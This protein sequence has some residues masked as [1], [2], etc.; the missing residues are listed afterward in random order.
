ML[1]VFKDLTIY[2]DGDPGPF[3][4]AATTQLPRAWTRNWERE[5]ELKKV[6]LTSEDRYVAFSRASSDGI[7]AATV[8]LTQSGSTLKV[9]NIVP[10]KL[11][12]LTYAQY[13]VILDDFVSQIARPAVDRLGFRMDL[14]PGHLPITHWLSEEAA[15]RLKRF[16]GAA[17][18]ATGS[19]HPMDFK[20]W[21]AFLIQ[22]HREDWRLDVET[23]ARW[24]TEEEGWGEEEAAKLSMEFEFARDLLKIYDEE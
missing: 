3:I 18:K 7:P 11:G 12:S 21:V 14:T 22:T 16:S 24:L 10:Q 5:N 13:N 9:T 2:G 17:N 15:R 6:A 23:L 4:E 20:R 8:F 1:E 19:T